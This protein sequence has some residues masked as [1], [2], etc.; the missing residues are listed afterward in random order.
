[1]EERTFFYTIPLR[2]RKN[3]W[4]PDRSK[5]SPK[6]HALAEQR[7][8][9]AK[10]TFGWQTDSPDQDSL[11]SKPEKTVTIPRSKME[12]ST[13]STEDNAST[14][15]NE[16]PL[17]TPAKGRRKRRQTPKTKTPKAISQ[18]TLPGD[19]TRARAAQ[20]R[21]EHAEQG[22]CQG[23]SRPAKPGSLQCETC[24]EYQRWYNNN[25][26]TPRRRQARTRE[27]TQTTAEPA[28]GPG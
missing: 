3:Y 10:A 18:P 27:R 11:H 15:K 4:L 21:K 13:T 9:F 14:A 22:L 17:P 25:V 7:V 23:C 19:A 16:L 26:G 28:T 1:M 5:T 24:L 12:E 20:T 6:Q 8:K 2:K